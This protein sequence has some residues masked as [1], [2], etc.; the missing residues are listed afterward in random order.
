[1]NEPGRKVNRN[2]VKGHIVK[3]INEVDRGRAKEVG[4]D[5]ARKMRVQRCKTRC[6]G[7]RQVR[8]PLISVGHPG[9]GGS[10]R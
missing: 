2:V 10:C 6:A 8:S 3:V 7:A 9:T 4:A 5:A 1:M